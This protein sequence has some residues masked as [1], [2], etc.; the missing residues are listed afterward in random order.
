M[1]YKKE[2]TMKAAVCYT[3]GQPLVVE[4]IEID[5]PQREEVKVRLA[6][7]AICHSDVHLIRGEWGGDVP[8]VAGHE[9]AGVVESVGDN[10]IL[11]Q[12]G[13]RVVVSLLRSCGRCFYCANG[14]AHMCEGTFALAHESRLRNQQGVPIHH[15]INTA[16]FAEYAIVHQSQ[17]V[18]IP[19]E[20][21]L[22]RAALLACGVITG[23]GAV[24]N[25]AR[26]R[27]GQSVVVIGTGGVGLNAIQ[28]AV[29]VG[30]HPIIAIDRLNPK[31]TSARAFGATHTVNA[32]EQELATIVR[33]LTSDRGADF[34]FVTV[35][36]PAAV[37]QALGIIRPGGTVVIV[38]IPEAGTTIPLLIDN[39]VF[40]EQRVIGSR[41]GSTQLSLDVPR[42][43][44]LY[45]H[46]RLKLDE[47]ITARYP[48]EQ[49]NEAINAMETGE[50]LRNVIVFD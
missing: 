3:F 9:A 19:D 41:M 18:R 20:L 47:L 15:G 50:V 34:A 42:L 2:Q 7:T 24:I 46:G 4:E 5:L 30:A 38:G 12:P 22:D 39:T 36:S 45:Q 21:P 29:L 49:I 27:P 33:A 43:V 40:D 44:E 17:L 35:G 23:T 16:A 31:L 37:A 6:A 8:V 25:T 10:V 11:A 1:Q 26:V 32:A 14:A 28:G 48:L 13:D